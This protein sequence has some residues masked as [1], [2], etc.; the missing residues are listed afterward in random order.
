VTADYLAGSSWICCA[1]APGRLEAPKELE[2]L[3][4]ERWPAEV[5]GTAAAALRAAGEPYLERDYDGEDWWFVTDFEVPSGAGPLRLALDGVATLHDVWLDGEHVH[6]GENMFLPATV[7]LGDCPGVHQLAIRCAALA[8]RLAVKVARP[9]WKTRLV[10]TQ[11]L[12]FVRTSLLGRMP[13]WSPGPAIVGPWR[14]VRVEPDDGVLSRHLAVEVA[15]GPGTDA[16]GLP[17]VG[18]VRLRL[19]LARTPSGPPV[20]SVGD[21]AAELAVSPR[22]DGGAL[23]EGACRVEGVERWWPHT[24]GGQRR[25]PARV[26]LDDEVVELGE[27]GFRTIEVDRGDG[28]FT[29]V[30][31]GVPVF[32]RGATW[33]PPDVVAPGNSRE[34]T[35]AA[36][37]QVRA[38]NLNIVRIPGT[39]VYEDAAFF[40]DCDDLGLLVWQ[41]CMLANLDPPS[42]AAFR[43]RLREELESVLTGLQGHPCLA[44]LCGGSEIEQQAAM[45]GAHRDR[46]QPEVLVR[47]VPEVAARIVPDVAYVTSS[48]SGGELPFRTDRGVAHYFG[49]GAYLRP[50]E[51][52][53]RADVRFAAEC[54]AFSVPPET[55]TVDEVFGGPGV[56]GHHPLWKSAVPRD[57]GAS[58]DFE[59]VSNHYATA[60]FGLDPQAVRRGDPELA[61]DL[62]RAAVAECFSAVFSEWRSGPSRCAGGIVLSLRDLFP[63]AGWGIVDA[64][65]RPKAPW[66]VLRRLLAPVAV[67]VTDE[68]LNGLRLHLAND[69]AELVE[70]QLA[71]ELYADGERLVERVTTG[72]ELPPRRVVTI[73]AAGLFEGFRDLTYAYRFGPPVH[74]VV[75]VTLETRRPE[76]AAEAV[77]LPLGPARPREVDVGLEA[78]VGAGEDGSWVVECRA[79]RFAQWVAID[80]PGFEAS[81]SWFHLAPG[82]ARRVRLDG[83]VGR[84]RA[85]GPRGELRALNSRRSAPIATGAS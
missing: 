34:A 64:L 80:V 32:C 83:P 48:P 41:D 85:A 20:L 27:V 45:A 60:L 47:D 42:D 67:L 14:A 73:E 33:V 11:S 61:L 37:V 62:V 70:A 26:A 63:G 58:F 54:L 12:R 72:V 17:T 78:V 24:H 21:A 76:Q 16:P 79:R 49:V 30:V 53:R 84:A 66:Y 56:A 6:Q 10:A 50:L 2:G 19:E 13:G 51:D 40:S 55:E 1:S 36:L 15:T 74:D 81:D 23:V 43:G 22:P 38:A 68:G 4:L 59:D 7:A 18:I 82:R 71:I 8:P 9:A 65:G 29:L 44:V 25:Y 31:N 46:W 39:M 52:T 57:A 3:A 77:Y 5:P 28:G 75:A 35:R 69:T